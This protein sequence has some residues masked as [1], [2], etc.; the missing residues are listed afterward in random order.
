MILSFNHLLTELFHLDCSS[1]IRKLQCLYLRLWLEQRHLHID[2]E[3]FVEYSCEYISCICFSIAPAHY[4]AKAMTSD[5][6]KSE[7]AAEHSS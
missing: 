1:L 6:H 5:Q 4:A 3:V 7:G 2:N